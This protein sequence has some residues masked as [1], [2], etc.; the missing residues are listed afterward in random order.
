M[1]LLSEAVFDLTVVDVVVDAGELSGDATQRG[2]VVEL[3]GGFEGAFL[4]VSGDEVD[5]Q[6]TVGRYR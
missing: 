3:Y 1:G 2:R 4:D 5:V 6:L